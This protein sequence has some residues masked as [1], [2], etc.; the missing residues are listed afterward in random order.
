M[1]MIHS[2][3]RCSD[4][5][6]DFYPEIGFKRTLGRLI[7]EIIESS[8]RRAAISNESQEVYSAYLRT[9]RRTV[10]VALACDRRLFML[11]FTEIGLT[12]A[13]LHVSDLYECAQAV[14]SWV[15]DKITLRDMNERFPN[16]EASEFAYQTEAGGGVSARWDALL[17][18]P[19]LQPEFIAL[20][21]AAARRPLLRQL[22][23]VASIG[24]YL[25]FSRTIGYPFAAINTCALW[26]KE[27]RYC[28]MGPQHR[29]L[30]E[31]TIEAVLDV[32]E[33]SVP[34]NAY[35]AIYGTADDLA[36]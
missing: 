25:S 18:A 9:G 23:P 35:L 15:A 26:A 28:A 19:W 33:T 34:P 8:G 5:P 29:A 3:R 10:S 7:L 13:Y 6:P 27:D 31:G 2:R 36:P 16:C 30:K 12:L 22:L 20:L 17:S 24:H 11:S 1:L 21:R 32:V 4:F 14:E